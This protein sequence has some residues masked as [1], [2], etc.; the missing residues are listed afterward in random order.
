[1]KRKYDFTT[2]MDRHGKD[3]IAVDEIPIPDAK[4]Q[5]GFSRIP[6]WVADMNFATPFP[7]FRNISL[8]VSIIRLLV[9]LILLRNTF[10]KSLTGNKQEIMLMD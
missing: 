1:M 6:M 9:T 3:S 7:P 4:I 8:H 2:I 10:K 5:E